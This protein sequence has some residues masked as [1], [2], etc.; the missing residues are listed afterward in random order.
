MIFVV[1]S[2]WKND[3]NRSLTPCQGIVSADVGKNTSR[4]VGWD[5]NRG[6]DKNVGGDAGLQNFGITL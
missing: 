6:A 5:T 4:D 3:D 2:L 1:G